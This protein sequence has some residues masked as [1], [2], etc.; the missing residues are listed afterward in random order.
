MA[1]R[2]VG[3]SLEGESTIRYAGTVLHEGSID[4]VIK[5]SGRVTSYDDCRRLAALTLAMRERAGLTRSC[6]VRL[7]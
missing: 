1:R 6:C 3:A 5:T 7:S 2:S 4:R